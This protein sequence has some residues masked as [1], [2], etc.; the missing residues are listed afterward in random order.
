[1]DQ[2]ELIRTAHR[3]Y[4][5]S[6]RQIARETG[7]TRKT[8]RKVLLGLTPKYRRKVEPVC[9]VMD[10]VGPMVEG[11][12]KTDQGE[13]RKQRHTAHR[14]YTR[15]VE[16]HCFKGGESTVRRWVR[17]RKARMGMNGALAVIPLDAEVA[18]E[19]EVD[20]GS[21]WVVMAGERRLIKFFSMRSRYSGKPFVRAYP[22]ERQEM[23]FDAHMRAFSFYGGIF[24]VLV[25]DN[26]TVAVR[27]ILR[28]KGRVEQER[29]TA[30][31]S[32]YTFEA[33][34]CNPAKGQ[35][36]GGVEG[37]VGFARRNFLVP[38][39]EV[40]DFDELN[41]LLLMRSIEHGERQIQGREDQRTIDQRHE[42][43]G[44]RLLAIPE[45]PF[46]N[47]KTLAVRISRYQTAQV[48][49]NRYS[50]PTAYVG[51]RLWAHID[52]D[53]ISLYAEQKKV[54]DHPRIFGKSRWQIDPLHYLELIHQR[55]GSFEAAR[56]IRQWRSQWPADYERMLA[57]LRAR[58]GDNDGT[59]E[60]VG[61]LQLHQNYPYPRVEDAVAE[62]L[63]CQ[64]YNLDSVKHI[65]VRQDHRE[66][67]FLPLYAGLIPG[68]TDLTVAA[69]DVGRY[70][71]L[72]AGGAR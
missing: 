21:A 72:L 13:S 15:L 32:Y 69:S 26:L 60:F 8:I 61:I 4:K 5:K 66:V 55:I 52:C 62:A 57:I 1:M 16:E 14:I 10:S 23:F 41:D 40:K 12:L 65:L 53:R 63:R 47:T 70:D 18:R 59:R 11:W 17:E 24:P 58:Q 35:E 3:V 33:R 71:L 29:F 20:W 6:I 27:Q 42:Q 19:A 36:K 49:W 39:P 68:V 67:A 28:G 48:E 54:A 44:E 2:Y 38:V 51:R 37:L 64:T 45:H 9:A 7:H 22:W 50:V 25:Y 31:R 34:F 56:P 43:E 30:F 46:E